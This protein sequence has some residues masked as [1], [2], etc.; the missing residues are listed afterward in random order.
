MNTPD[1]IT[2]NPEDL[3]SQKIALKKFDVNE[4]RKDF[5]F[6]NVKPYGKEPVYLD[7]AAS[8]QKP[9][10][11]LRVMDQTYRESY[12]NV[13]RGLHYFANRATEA[14]EGARGKVARFLNAEF[15]SEIIWTKGATEGI[16]LIAN[17]YG[18]TL[19]AG[20]EII[21]SV[22]EH[23]S[24]IVPWTL[25][26][27]RVGVKLVVIPTD[28]RGD[29]DMIAFRAAFTD[30]TVLVTITHM[31]NIL[32]TINPVREI[33]EYAHERGV[34][35]LLD[36]SQAVP[37]A[38]VDLREIGADFYVFTGHK[39][40]GP[41]GIGAVYIKK[42]I[43]ETLPPWQGGGEMIVDVDFDTV[44]YALPPHRFEAGTPPI[45]QAVGL[46]AAIDYVSEFNRSDVLA[47]EK[48]LMIA[49]QEGLARIDGVKIHGTSE[50]KGAIITFS[51]DGTHPHDLAT[52]LDRLG[53][54][55]RAGHHCGQPLMRHLGIPSAARASFAMYNLPEDV[56]K[57]VDGVR[58]AK[59]FFA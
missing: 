55:V 38:S 19:K 20:D 26:R 8:V 3:S 2:R 18:S 6:L 56:E 7:N 5:P 52:Y 47:H 39:L 33:V 13:H 9:T 34:K 35:V 51:V 17:S 15:E 59:A 41:S 42:E 54:A 36:G 24:N 44:T 23:H 11:V 31:S 57:L 29:L 21:L 48:S 22:A 14:F 49:A 4:I 37:H 30:R 58:K 32:G 45:V 12:A 1:L 46:G 27:E 40:Y 53:I 28:M 50:S 43:A 10:A 16:N 25:L